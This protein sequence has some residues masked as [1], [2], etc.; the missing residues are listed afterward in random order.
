MLELTVLCFV[1]L[2]ALMNFETACLLQ[3]GIVHGALLQADYILV[4]IPHLTT[5][6]VT[7]RRLSLHHKQC[8]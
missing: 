1:T 6:I 7:A 3:D 8:S 5:F 2:L 4:C